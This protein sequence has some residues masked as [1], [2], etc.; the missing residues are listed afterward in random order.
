M[1]TNYLDWGLCP[2][3]Q[4]PRPEKES[5][6]RSPDVCQ[7]I[8][9]ESPWRT[10]RSCHLG[11]RANN[12]PLCCHLP[13]PWQSLCS[14]TRS[15]KDRRWLCRA[16]IPAPP[17]SILGKVN[18]LTFRSHIHKFLNRYIRQLV[19]RDCWDLPSCV[20]SIA[21]SELDLER[22][23]S[24]LNIF[25]SCSYSGCSPLILDTFAND[26]LLQ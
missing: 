24:H 11:E 12:L 8:S 14:S 13:L 22:S 15:N 6:Y 1:S 19:M 18:A 2:R 7:F 16:A 17:R 3:S 23:L 21:K 26:Y 4:D 25:P 9:N 5:L 20:T 10:K